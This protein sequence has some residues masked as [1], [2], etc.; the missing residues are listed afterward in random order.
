VKLTRLAI[1]DVVLVT[2]KLFGD[3]RGWF[4][5]TWHAGKFADGGLELAFVQDNHS[6][7]RAG[8]LRG[9]HYQILHPQGKLVR[10]LRGEIF[11]VAVDLRRSSPTFGRWV[12]EVLSAENKSQLYVPPGFAHGFVVT[13]DEAEMAYKCTDLYHPEHERTILWN[14]A[15]LGIEWPLPPGV[16]PLLSDKDRAGTPFKD[17][18]VFI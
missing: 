13:S 8:T 9:L 2:P 11:D 10:V 5:E 15:D 1:P 17:A 18:E 3:A 6:Y 7:S 4:M 14:D 12:G 16:A